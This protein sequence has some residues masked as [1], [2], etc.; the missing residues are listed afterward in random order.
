MRQAMKE[1]PI[2]DKRA[3]VEKVCAADSDRAQAG[4][5]DF[6][7][8]SVGTEICASLVSGDLWSSNQMVIIDTTVWIDYLPRS[9]NKR[10]RL[11]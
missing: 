1:Q 10:D 2:T 6:E 3:A 8:R 5:R 4:I 9:A 7:A 11:L